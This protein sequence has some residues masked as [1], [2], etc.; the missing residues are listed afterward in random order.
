M[1][2]L[3]QTRITD[4]IS[5]HKELLKSEC[6]ESIAR[7]AGLIVCCYKNGGK[8]LLC[9]NGGSASDAQHIESE[10]VGRFKLE[11][12]A[13][14]AI[15]LSA[16]TS[17]ITSVGNDYGY[18][19]VFKRG[20]E[21]YG[22]PGDVLIAISTSGNSINVISAINQAKSQGLT[23]VCLAGCDGGE[24]SHL[25][26]IA[27]VIPSYDTPRIQEC[28]IMVGHIICELVEKSLFGE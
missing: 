20:V 8:V 15:A 14:P 26:D 7:I 22:K 27:F 21:A 25:A 3:V 16:N 10:L 23:I 18:Q 6:M 19:D 13:L 4:N 5:V 28:H 12:K 9:G 11:R 17:T 24:M 1:I 2:E